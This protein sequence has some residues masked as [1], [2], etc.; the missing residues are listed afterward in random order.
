M[1]Q[2]NKE[3]QYHSSI[4]MY[5]SEGKK[6]NWHAESVSCPEFNW[7]LNS[8]GLHDFSQWHPRGRDTMT[9][10]GFA[11][12]RFFPSHLVSIL[13][14]W[15]EPI[16]QNKQSSSSLAQLTEVKQS[17]SYTQEGL[18]IVGPEEDGCN[19]KQIPCSIRPLPSSCWSR[20]KSQIKES[21][22]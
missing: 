15:M 13:Q 3:K 7:T 5:D 6:S 2:P 19:R 14:S 4:K 20:R 11:I 8:P 1:S 16:I 22:T 12:Q 21:R 18:F 10:S 17:S 9:P